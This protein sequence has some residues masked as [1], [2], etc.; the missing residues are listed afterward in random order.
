MCILPDAYVWYIFIMQTLYDMT[1][2]KTYEN[3]HGA[4]LVHDSVDIIVPALK[5]RQL[6]S[7]ESET[8][9]RE[10]VYNKLV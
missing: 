3:T 8:R 6:L 5:S 10:W 1:G 7:K 2:Q 9:A 4:N